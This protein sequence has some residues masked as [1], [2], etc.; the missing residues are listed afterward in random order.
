[1]DNEQITQ[2]ALLDNRPAEE[3]EKDY[4]FE[5]IVASVNKVEWVE[6]PRSQWRKFPIYNQDG[7]GSCV[8]QTEAKEMGIMRWLK[9][10]IYVHFSAADIYQRRSNK[11]GSGMYGY[12]ARKIVKDNGATLEVLAPSQNMND[13]QMDSL[14]IAEYKKEV[15]KVFKVSN[16]VE[17]TTKDIDTIASIIQTTGKAVML[18]FYFEYREWTDVPKILNASLQSNGANTCRHSVAGVDFILCG[19]S[20]MPE[21]PETWGKKAI[22]IDESWG[23]NITKFESQRVITEDFFNARN[24]YRSYLVNFK[25]DEPVEPEPQPEPQP[26]PEPNKPKYTFNRDLEFSATYKVD[27]DVVALQNILKYEGFFPSN[28]QS[29]GYFGAITK[30]AVG[31]YQTKYGIAY[32]GNAGFG[33]VGPKTRAHLNSKYSK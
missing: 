21:F 32:A 19:R 4:T 7:S 33:R 30:T 26:Q 12:N 18:W 3:K 8:A 13:Q 16:F 10:G 15:G 1:M 6:K 25:F 9:D 28:T 29:T 11:P 31:K 17:V 24:F 5:E 27:Q 22:L 23:P 14:E 20:N 2:A